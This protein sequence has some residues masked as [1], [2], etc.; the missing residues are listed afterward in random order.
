M[1]SQPPHQIDPIKDPESPSRSTLALSFASLGIVFG[2]I[3]TS[4][5]YTLNA[6]FTST[7]FGVQVSDT[8]VY[9]VLSLVFWSMLLVL[10][11]KYL[12][13]LVRAQNEGEGGIFAMLALIM[14]ARVKG[15]SSARTI[16][17]VLIAIIG[18]ALLYGDGVVTPAI[19]VLSAVEGLEHISAELAE[20]VVPIALAILVVLFLWQR[21]GTQR[22]AIIFSPI[23]LLWFLVIG[24]LGL[25]QIIGSPGILK[26]VNPVYAFEL[27][28]THPWHAF[29]LLGLIVLCV[30]GAE[31]LYADLG[32]FSR[33]AITI[34]WCAVVWPCLL[35]SYF[36]QGAWLLSQT[37]AEAWGRPVATADIG[38][39]FFQ[40]IP[41][42]F[43]W[44]MVILAAIA[45]FIAS[46]AIITGAFSLT[47]QAVQMRILP[48]L[49][50]I[51]TSHEV[52]GQVFLPV[53]NRV[54]FLGC[55]AAVLLF[56]SSEDLASAYGVAVT[57]V[58]TTTTI[59][60]AIIARRVWGW[61]PWKVIPVIAVFLC[62]DLSF[63]GA[64]L[65][66]LGS[67]GWFPISIAAILVVLMTTWRTGRLDLSKNNPERAEPI[68][69]FLAEAAEA[70]PH[71]ITG[72]GVYLTAT[73]ETTPTSLK[74]LFDHMPVLYDRVIIMSMEAM[75]VARI[76]RSQQLE[77]SDLGNGFTMICGRFG[78][79]QMPNV[80]RT[81][82]L[83]VNAG[84][85]VDL[86]TI[87]YYTKREVVMTKG[88]SSMWQWR[89]G[90]HAW[91]ARNASSMSDV[92]E[93]PADKVVE[94]G[95]RVNL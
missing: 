47:R 70:S 83:A 22:I 63:L 25:V 40:I 89:K 38:N 84:L 6:C 57:T 34:A 52:E 1:T 30:T 94:I 29:L 41:E 81:L 75:P 65:F 42:Q 5:L 92:F 36:G 86:K 90:L 8:S 17:I 13:F 62:F 60:L 54:M 78:Y 18:A 67:G 48:Y 93:L 26:A 49:R 14:Q 73:K 15:G 3:G 37:H 9:G 82:Q 43:M 71:R 39:P 12:T 31:A 20:F 24:Y 19:S 66:K 2:D 91:M 27:F 87:T 64:N 72:T 10:S 16:F 53:V 44:P 85:E 69:D 80:P 55:A 21:L 88:S 74:V 68:G 76:P 50:I 28:G 45:A 51:H 77:V 56:Q 61:A 95:V 7:T 58:M 4:P 33:R 11:V 46:Q 35:L 59:L 79:L 23:M 32:Q